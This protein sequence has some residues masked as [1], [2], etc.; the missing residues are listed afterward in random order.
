VTSASDPKNVRGGKGQIGKKRKNKER[1]RKGTGG[2]E[3]CGYPFPH[4]KI[5]DTPLRSP[6]FK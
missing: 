5:L 6:I 1:G 4:E 3:G 2:T